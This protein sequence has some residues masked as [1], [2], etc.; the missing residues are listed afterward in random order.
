MTYTPQSVWKLL[1]DY[2]RRAQGA[3][4][5]PR[6]DVLVQRPPPLTEAPY[7]A[8]SCLWA[9]IETAMQNL[10]FRHE[11]ILWETV[12]RGESS[13]RNGT[14]R[15][16]WRRQVADWWGI[17][18]GDVNKLVKESIQEMCDFLNTDTVNEVSRGIRRAG[19]GPDRT[20]VDNSAS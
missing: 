15:Y 16:D 18:P 5:T 8:S 4:M 3:R 13:A 6:E 19:G 7:A 20:K 12:C 2:Q 9:D 14:K 17:T 10:P 1:A 11:K